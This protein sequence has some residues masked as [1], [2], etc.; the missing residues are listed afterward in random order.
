MSAGRLEFL[1]ADTDVNALMY[2]VLQSVLLRRRSIGVSITL[3]EFLPEC[4]ILTDRNRVMQ[5]ILNFMTNATKYTKA[6]SIRLGYRMENPKFITFY[7]SD[8]GCGLA[9]VEQKKVF[10]RFVKLNPFV[11]GTDWD[12]RSAKLSW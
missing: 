2:D 8:T 6:G 12:C 10:E 5:V 3:D 4:V 1:N 11:Q 9:E 7:V